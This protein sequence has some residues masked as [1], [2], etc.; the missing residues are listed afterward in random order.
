MRTPNRV[1]LSVE[2]RA[3]LQRLVATG[4][5]EART[6]THAHILLKADAT[7]PGPGWRDDQIAEAFAVSC[8]TVGRVRRR[9]VTQGV[10]AALHRQPSRRQY[11]RRLDGDQ[12]AHLVAM[13]CGAPPEGR[14]R[15]TLR[16]L[17]DKVVELH[18]VEDISYET[19]RRALKKTR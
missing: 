4:Q 10:A 2:E 13:A 1:T 18:L 15:W 7:A 9:Y 6:L 19:V 17:A 12:E 14:K 11:R 8:S 16:L 5:T 3:Q